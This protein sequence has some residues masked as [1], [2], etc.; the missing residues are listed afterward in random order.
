MG[1]KDRFP[2][3]AKCMAMMR[4][5]DALTQ[6]H[7]FHWLRPHAA[8]FVEQLMAE[9]QAETKDFGLKCWLVELIGEARDP[10]ALPLLADLLQSSEER[11]RDRAVAALRLM[12]TSES[13][14]V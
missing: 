5:R 8:E 7:G 14:R 10:R 9:F 13:R 3:F 2:G 12:D 6:E 4:K 11:L 1:K